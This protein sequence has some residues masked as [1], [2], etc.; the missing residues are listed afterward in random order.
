M[1]LLLFPF[2]ALFLFT[3]CQEDDLSLE[4]FE[5]TLPGRWE[6]ESMT[7]NELYSASIFQGDT[8]TEDQVLNNAGFVEFPEFSADDLL[9]NSGVDTPMPFIVE[10]D[11]ELFNFEMEYLSANSERYF[12][13]FRV[14]DNNSLDSEMGRFLETTLLFDQNSNITISDQNTIFIEPASGD[15]VLRLERI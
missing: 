13:A 7:I 6:I 5:R 8:I 1:K 3:S 2:L 10:L 12:G 11:A 9:L 15:H 14:S 4:D